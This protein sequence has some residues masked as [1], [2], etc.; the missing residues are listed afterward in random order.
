[1]SASDDLVGGKS[2]LWKWFTLAVVVIG[3]PVFLMTDFAL[4]KAQKIV[5]DNDK[6]PWAGTLQRAIAIGYSTKFDHRKAAERYEWASRFAFAAGDEEG[7]GW[8]LF[9]QAVEVEAADSNGKWAALPM[10]ENLANTYPDKPVGARAA[11][12][13][14]RIKTMGRP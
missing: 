1:M 10:Y 14:T 2:S 5:N 13:V 3:I 11:G 7:G 4:E 12:N 9:N 6:K 8:L